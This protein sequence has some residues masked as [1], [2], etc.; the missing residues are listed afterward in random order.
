MSLVLTV[1][2]FTGGMS[3]IVIAQSGAP[4]VTLDPFP[5]YTNDPTPTL[6]G[7][8]TATAPGTRIDS[9]EYM[10]DSGGWISKNEPS[11]AKP[12]DG[13]WDE[14]IEDFT[15]TTATLS[16]GLHT[17]EVRAIDALGN[18]TAPANYATATFTVDTIAPSIALTPLSPDPTNDNTPTISGTATDTT[19]PI[20]SV[21]YRVDSGNWTAAEA[22]DGTFNEFSEDFTFT[23]AE[24][25]DGEHL[26]KTR[27]TDAAGNVSPLA[28]DDFTVDATPPSLTL[29]PLPSYTN[30]PTPTFSGT[31]TDTISSIASVQYRIDSG[32]WTTTI[33]LDGAFDE[34]VEGYALTTTTL[35][36]GSH[37]LE[38]RSWDVLGNAITPANYAIATFI[39][40][41]TPPSIALTPL[42]P[43]PT[44]DNTPTLSGIATDTTSPIISVKYRVDGGGWI[45]AEAIDGTFNELSEDFAFTIAELDDGEH[46]VQVRATDAAGNVSPLASHAFTVDAT[47]PSVT[48]NPFPDYTN[49]NTP[50][51]SGIAIDTNSPITSVEYRV[52]GGGWI[53]AE[54]TDGTFNELSENFIFTIAELDDG[55]HLVE[56]RTTDAA[57]NVSPMASDAFTVDTTPPSV[58]LNPFPN[59]TNDNTPTLSGIA[60]DTTSPITSVEYRVDS[61][62]WIAAEATDGTF[63]ELSEDFIFTIAGLD[64]GEH[65]VEVRT[66]DAVGN[67]S[68]LASYAFTVDTTP[69]SVTLN[70]FP[71]YT[72]DNT[73]ILSG[74]A[75]DT[76]SPITSVEYRVDSGDWIAAEA[77]DGTFN[78]LSENFIFTIAGLDDG[79]HLVEVRTTDAAGN[80][81]PMASDAFT[82]DTTAP[83]L[84]LDPFPSYTNDPT[85][86]FSGTA[87]DTLSPIASVQYRFDG[88]AWTPATIV[89]GVLDE[90]TEEYTLTT[91]TLVDG[92]HTLEVQAWDALGNTTTLA[93]YATATFTIDTTPPSIALILLSPDPTNDNTPTLS[94][95]ATDTTSPITSVEYRVDGEDWIAAEATDGTFDE[96]S[97][98][99]T[100]TIAELDAGEHLVEVKT[101]DAAGNISSLASHAFVVD[102]ALPSVTIGDIPDSVNQ[103]AS[104]TGTASDDPPGV[105]ERVQVLIN[106]SSDGTY[107]DSAAWVTI[108]RW[109]DAAGTESW[110]YDMPTLTEGKAYT[111]KAKSIDRA[112]NESIEASD[113]FTSDTT[114]PV[115]PEPPSPEEES[116][117]LDRNAPWL[118]IIVSGVFGLILVTVLVRRRKAKV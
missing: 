6:T 103:L 55:E 104:I 52:D 65:L 11:G 105:I 47:P 8:A 106:N 73:P 91:T 3:A 32:N 115:V 51:I 71:D 35:V 15:F 53:A 21:E 116:S 111:V 117:F 34:L 50:T 45:A 18:A 1:A 75:I 25:D 118:W 113:S 58:T 36:D 100:F 85:P 54:A 41:T 44:N 114:S 10:I 42:S 48:L 67:V 20:T 77:T 97:E 31:A 93:N 84:I 69:P 37:T 7:T 66:T 9:V 102:T 98:D 38:V 89:D 12:D 4:S 59:Y 64:D 109:L 16:N 76:T 61:G 99:F 95:T 80:V 92:S 26:V 14:P 72:N 78:E 46:L 43:D 88:G 70:P 49:D 63:N 60:I 83:S 62:D 19:S 110:S 40:D 86:T 28:S 23:I 81:S 30:N 57:G 68:L 94:G 87:T 24:L 33:A 56:V 27:A 5:D 96:L 74:L 39:V 108:K 79:E 2:F 17:I 107:W 112:G 101:T 13:A 90:L 22:T 29:N 82:V